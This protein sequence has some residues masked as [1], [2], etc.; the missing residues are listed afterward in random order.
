MGASVK[1]IA[2]LEGYLYMLLYIT[3]LDVVK[4]GIFTRVSVTHSRT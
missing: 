4:S 1:K 3:L 2:G